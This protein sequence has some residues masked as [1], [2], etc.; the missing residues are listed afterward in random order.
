MVDRRGHLYRARGSAAVTTAGPPSVTP[1]PSI[2]NL[3]AATSPGNVPKIAK[4]LEASAQYITEGLL[5][6]VLIAFGGITILGQHPFA[7][8]AALGQALVKQANDA[9]ANSLDAQSTAT[10]A[11]TKSDNLVDYLTNAITGGTSAGN[12]PEQLQTLLSGLVQSAKTAAATA[13]SAL[14]SQG[15]LVDFIVNGLRNT[16]NSG[17]PP[18]ILQTVFNDLRG[19]LTQAANTATTAYTTA[20][21]LGG[22]LQQFVQ[23]LDASPVYADV[24]DFLT[25]IETTIGQLIGSVVTS[26]TPQNPGTA[27]NAGQI[28][29]LLAHIDPAA[30]NYRYVFDSTVPLSANYAGPPPTSSPAWTAPTGFSLPQVPSGANYAYGSTTAQIGVA[31]GNPLASTSGDHSLITDR[32]HVEATVLYLAVG[33]TEIFLCGH[34][35]TALTQHVALRFD[36][37][38]YGDS[39]AIVTY[40]AANTSATIRLTQTTGTG[41]VRNLAVGDVIAIEYDNAGNFEL[42]LNGAGLSPAWNDSTGAISHGPGYREIGLKEN[43]N[44]TNPAFSGGGPGLGNFIAYDY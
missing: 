2:H 32:V 44:S 23:G 21:A 9:Y 8:L 26:L 25:Q 40:T 10:A 5:G 12:P 17:N 36:H 4:E 3:P 14:E 41:L 33:W 39:L 22:I 19:S 24:N 20:T 7:A 15:G 11:A 37:E 6:Q 38:G 27:A 1:V 29:Y 43:A 16:S 13:A 31:T 18:E 28:N 42:F 35:T 34:G 30:S